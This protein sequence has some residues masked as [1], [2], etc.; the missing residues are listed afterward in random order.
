MRSREEVA[1]LLGHRSGNLA[2][3]LCRTF[4]ATLGSSRGLGDVVRG[5]VTDAAGQVPN[6]LERSEFVSQVVVRLWRRLLLA[7]LG[8]LLTCGTTGGNASGGSPPGA[9][10][11]WSRRCCTS[12]S[13]TPSWGAVNS[14]ASPST[15][16]SS[17]SP[18]TWA[19]RT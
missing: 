6:L 2:I 8:V 5:T 1:D 3:D 16:R 9:T 14:S 17:S 15:S 19:F 4:Q 18:V 7:H 12:S 10:K 11:R 13:P